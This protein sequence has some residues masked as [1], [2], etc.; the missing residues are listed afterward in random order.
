MAKD[1]RTQPTSPNSIPTPQPAGFIKKKGCRAAA[2]GSGGGG[3][4]RFFLKNPAGWD[5]GM[6]F[7][8]VACVRIAFAINSNPLSAH[9]D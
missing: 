8:D 7:G 2:A 9:S 5:V 1:M 6:E 4:Q 3:R